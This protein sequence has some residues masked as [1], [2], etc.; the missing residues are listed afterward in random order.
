MSAATIIVTLVVL[1]VV[2]SVWAGRTPETAA[3]SVPP[4]SD[5]EDGWMPEAT[6]LDPFDNESGQTGNLPSENYDAYAGS[7]SAL[8]E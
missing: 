2:L 6:R 3:T 5:R 8:D 7:K 1:K 4:E